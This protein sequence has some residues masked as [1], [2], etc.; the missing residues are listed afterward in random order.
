M[1]A[2]FDI[3]ENTYAPFSQFNNKNGYA[4]FHPSCWYIN[5]VYRDYM[6]HIR[7]VLDQ[8]MS[9]LTGHIIKWDHSFKLPKLLTKLNGVATFAG[10]F[11]L[12]N[13]FEQIRFQAFVPTKSLSHIR[14]SFE[15]LSESLTA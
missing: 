12:V 6:E 5:S 3:T 8:C 14:A 9:A 1:A 15:K 2:S 13:E 10:L 7:P 4:G 11:T